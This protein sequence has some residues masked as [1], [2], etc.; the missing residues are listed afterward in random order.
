MGI[1]QKQEGVYAVP[2]DKAVLKNNCR[3]IK[4]SELSGAENSVINEFY[5]QSA[6]HSEATKL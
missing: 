3:D 2:I 1:I 6:L 4:G 5:K